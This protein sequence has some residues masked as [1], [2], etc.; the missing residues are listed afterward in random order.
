[1]KTKIALCQLNPL[2]GKPEVNYQKIEKVLKDYS[3]EKIA[4]F[5]FPEDFL[6]G[7]LR[8]HNEILEAGNHFRVW[9]K[10]FSSL[11][12]KYNVDLIPGSFPVLRNDK[13][14]NTTIY[15]DKK[16]RILNEYS[17]TNLWLSE[18]DEYSSNT[19]P[20]QC[21]HSVLGKT[22]QI[23]CWDIMNHKLFEEV[24]KQ[25]AEWIINISLWSTNQTRDLAKRRGKTKNK[26]DIL[27]RKSERLDSII[28]TRSTEY[29]IGMIFCNIG[30][31]HNYIALDKKNQQARSAGRTQII[32]PLNGIKKIVSSRKEQIF[33]CKIPDIKSYLSDHEILYG[34]REDIQNDCPPN[35]VIASLSTSDVENVENAIKGTIISPRLG[36]SV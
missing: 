6:H 23:I 34:R 24:V 17:K 35:M 14:F 3:R 15:I 22:A 18:R 13:L 36:Y 11:A 20:P 10:K 12:K 4:L 26:Y 27:V 32:T 2:S 29:N 19:I 28:E 5:I 30:G 7:I 33:I 31:I 25:G 16:G 21:F 8:G 9:V 1:M